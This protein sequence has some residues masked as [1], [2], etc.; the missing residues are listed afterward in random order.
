MVATSVR[1]STCNHVE[2]F[3][4]TTKRVSTNQINRI[5]T[6]LKANKIDPRQH[7]APGEIL[8]RLWR[9]A[10]EELV[11]LLAFCPIDALALFVGCHTAVKTK[12]PR[13]PKETKL[14]PGKRND[15]CR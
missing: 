5:G 15:S 4:L 7:A 2:L 1:T 3:Q 6:T 10:V 8:E 14:S 12:R 11:R 9:E 13:P